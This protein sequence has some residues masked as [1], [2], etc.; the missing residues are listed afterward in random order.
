M[1]ELAGAD[2]RA[3]AAPDPA[4]QIVFQGQPGAY[5]HLACRQ[6]YATDGYTQSLQNL[7]QTS[8]DTDMVFSDGYSLQ[9]AT[10]TGSV[11][12]RNAT[13]DL[14]NARPSAVSMAGPAGTPA[15]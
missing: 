5:S 9:L 6:V 13:I 1:D 12:V 3:A 10:V 2:K 14:A 8:L 4:Q 15:A 7:A 11:P